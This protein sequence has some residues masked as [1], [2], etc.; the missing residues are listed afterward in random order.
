MKLKVLYN[1]INQFIHSYKEMNIAEKTNLINSLKR[2]DWIMFWDFFQSPHTVYFVRKSNLGL[3]F[4]N[5]EGVTELILF[6]NFI[7]VEIDRDGSI[8]AQDY[9]SYY[10]IF[11]E[12]RGRRIKLKLKD[13]K[14]YKNINFFY[15][16][17][18]KIYM[19]RIKEI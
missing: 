13:I 18:E 12:L 7:A 17:L 11:F 1:K 3:K 2:T 19:E 10:L 4:N 16:L 8:N 15:F 5:D 14:I 9:L 6:N